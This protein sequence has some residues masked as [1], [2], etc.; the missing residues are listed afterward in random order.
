M[1][2]SPSRL[3]RMRSTRRRQGDGATGWRGSLVGV[4]ILARCPAACR[5]LRLA[6]LVAITSSLATSARTAAGPPTGPAGGAGE[7]RAAHP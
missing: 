7:G 1:D 5:T 2:A 3:Q 4:D 6:R